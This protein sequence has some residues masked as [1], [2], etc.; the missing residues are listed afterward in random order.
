[1]SIPSDYLSVA[2]TNEAVF[3]AVLRDLKANRA[4]RPMGHYVPPDLDTESPVDALFEK[5]SAGSR[6]GVFTIEDF[7]ITGEEALISFADIA[8]LSGGGASLVYS[9]SG[10]EV[11]YVRAAGVMMS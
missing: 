4:K 8:T 6:Y 5:Y 3:R 11:T 10:D 2:K 1:M 9:I 7:E